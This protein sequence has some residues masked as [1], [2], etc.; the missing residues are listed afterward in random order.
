MSDDEVTEFLTTEKVLNIA[1]IGPSGHPHMVAMWYVMLDG[2][3]TFWTFGRSQKIKNLERDPKITGL[4]EAGDSYQELR[5]AEVRGTAVLLDDPATV[6]EIGLAVA[7]K[8]NGPEAVSDAARPFIEA[9]VA[10][11]IGVAIDIEHVASW[12][13]RKIKGY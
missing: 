4:V 10:K 7:E 6:L 12:D 9:Q 13:H 2:K 5:G 1:T 3:P 8:Y 11:R